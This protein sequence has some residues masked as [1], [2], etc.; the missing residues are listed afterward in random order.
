[1]TAPLTSPVNSS[2]AAS[3]ESRARARQKGTSALL[4]CNRSLR[5]SNR[6]R[7]S[8]LHARR[9][10]AREIATRR[11]HAR[12]P[13]WGR[14]GARVRRAEPG[15]TRRRRRA[16]SRRSMRNAGAASSRCLSFTGKGANAQA[17]MNEADEAGDRTQ[18]GARDGTPRFALFDEVCEGRPDLL[19][20]VK[21][22]A[23][24]PIWPKHLVSKASEHDDLIGKGRPIGSRRHKTGR[25]GRIVDLCR[26][27]L[28]RCDRPAPSAIIECANADEIFGKE[29]ELADFEGDGLIVI[30]AVSFVRFG[31]GDAEAE[32]DGIELCRVGFACPFKI[33]IAFDGLPRDHHLPFKDGN[34]PAARDKAYLGMMMTSP[35]IPMRL[36]AK[37]IGE[38]ERA[39]AFFLGEK[40]SFDAET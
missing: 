7:R 33:L 38:G 8:R 22:C 1:M 3:G 4:N 12:C 34:R 24:Q 20:G 16:R 13:S 29:A 2:A 19:V 26:R 21:K 11:A 32:S 10:R 30:G 23:P 25:N 39:R 27:K 15:R 28:R 35:L 36:G 37:L 5:R 31:I 18:E 40:G 9:G 14:R 6:S 17:L